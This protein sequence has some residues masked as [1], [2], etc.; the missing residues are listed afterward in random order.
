M[1]FLLLST[2]VEQD[3]EWCFVIP[4]MGSAFKELGNLHRD[5]GIYVLDTDE[6]LLFYLFYS[7]GYWAGALLH[8]LSD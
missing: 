5:K 1:H 7:L 4:V 3:H 8:E 6:H 2:G